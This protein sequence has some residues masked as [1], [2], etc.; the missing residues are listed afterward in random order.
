[1]LVGPLT[2]AGGAVIPPRS[3]ASHPPPPPRSDNSGEYKGPGDFRG[4]QGYG[5]QHSAFVG[6]NKTFFQKIWP[7]PEKD[8]KVE[9]SRRT[10]V[11]MLI[12]S[13][14]A[15]G[16]EAYLISQEWPA[17][18]R[19]K[20]SEKADSYAFDMKFQREFRAGIMYHS[21]FVCA[22]LFGLF[23][24][25][26][27]L[28][29]L[30]RN[31][32]TS[33]FN[34][35]QT[36]A[37][38][39]YSFGIL[40]YTIIQITQTAKTFNNAQAASLGLDTVKESKTF[41]GVEAGLVGLAL[42]WF[43]LIAF[44]AWQLFREFGWRIY[45]RIGGNIELERGFFNF[46]VFLLM[47]KYQVFFISMFTTFILV[48]ATPSDPSTAHKIIGVT[49]AVG[50]P[51]LAGTFVSGYYGARLERK[52]LL[53]YCFVGNF[54]LAG[55]VGYYIYQCYTS[56]ANEA[57]QDNLYT[58]IQNPLY[59]FGSMSLLA[60]LVS[61]IYTVVCSKR[62]KTGLKDVLDQ[63]LKSAPPPKPLDLDE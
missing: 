26:D 37:V 4:Q 47:N 42:L 14:A 53:F 43:L 51:W 20:Q 31:P 1:M 36:L 40:F 41:S 24:A 63:S 49:C 38:V 61:M 59:F 18:L 2:G 3:M 28:L 25:W 17:Y 8:S 16:M 52:L 50:I 48:L 11:A 34:I 32:M 19:F 29:Y 12:Y 27:A 39:I 5:T 54:G 23:V 30:T 22:I 10:L 33:Q 62:F 13:A 57:D 45:R 35:I 7:M 60:Q 55:Y 21:A 6:K 46:H 9:W 58:G 44:M 15:L 56:T